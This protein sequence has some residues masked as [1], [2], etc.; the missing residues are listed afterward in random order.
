MKLALYLM[1]LIPHIQTVNGFKKEMG[2]TIHW[3]SYGEGLKRVQ[4]LLSS[5]SLPINEIFIT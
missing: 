4:H 2:K 1:L 5:T 3:I